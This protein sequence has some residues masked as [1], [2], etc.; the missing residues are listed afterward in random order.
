MAAKENYHSQSEYSLFRKTNE[1]TQLFR[2]R[3]PRAIHF[4]SGKRIAGLLLLGSS[5]IADVG[6]HLMGFCF[7]DSVLLLPGERGVKNVLPFM[8][9]FSKLLNIFLSVKGAWDLLGI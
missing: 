7:L 9:L 2:R 4:S 1:S 6:K 3:V 8:I 5:W